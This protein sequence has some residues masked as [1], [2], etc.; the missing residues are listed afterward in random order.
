MLPSLTSIR[1]QQLFGPGNIWFES[2]SRYRMAETFTI[3]ELASQFQVTTRAI[4]FYEDKGL[5]SPGRNGRNRVYSKRD[6]TRLKLVLRGK[7]LGFTLDETREII[8]MYDGHL[9]GERQ[10]LMR[11]CEK[12]QESRQVLTQQLEDIKLSLEE[13]DRIEANCSRQLA[14]LPPIDD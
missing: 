9:S 2:R 12:I 8:D 3:S 14:S 11:M 7:R 10:Q 4:R 1:A 6:R 5:L 13:M